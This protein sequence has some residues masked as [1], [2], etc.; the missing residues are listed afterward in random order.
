MVSDGQCGLDRELEESF[1]TAVVP[2]VVDVLVERNGGQLE[3]DAQAAPEQR[4]ELVDPRPVNH[5]APRAGHGPASHA[6]T[7]RGTA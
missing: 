1:P 2:R 5:S 6:S 3:Q 7:R 4:E